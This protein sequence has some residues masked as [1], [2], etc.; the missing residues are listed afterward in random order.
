MDELNTLADKIEDES[1]DMFDDE[2]L[3][4]LFDEVVDLSN[5]PQ[6]DY[7]YVK[8]VFDTLNEDLVDATED[9]VIKAIYDLN[10]PLQYSSW[11][12][13]IKGELGE[14]TDN[15]PMSAEDYSDA[16]AQLKAL[17]EAFANT[18]TNEDRN[19]L[20][21]IVVQGRK[22]LEKNNY[23]IDRLTDLKHHIE[24]N[25]EMCK[26]TY[27]ELVSVGLGL[28]S[29]LP[30]RN[31]FTDS[32]S[33]VNYRQAIEAVDGRLAA[34]GVIGGIVG[35]GIIYKIFKWIREKFFGSAKDVAEKAGEAAEATTALLEEN[36]SHNGD[37][38]PKESSEAFYD[39]ITKIYPFTE[40]EKRRI[41]SGD[42]TPAQLREEMVKKALNGDMTAILDG[43]STEEVIQ[44]I[45]KS[46]NML[47]KE[48][49]PTMKSII[50]SIKTE[51]AS[52]IDASKP[53][54]DSFFG[55]LTSFMTG[56]PKPP[57]NAGNAVESLVKN[58]KMIA[59]AVGRFADPEFEKMCKK[60]SDDTEDIIKKYKGA[61]N[62]NDE[63]MKSINDKVEKLKEYQSK[64][65]NVTRTLAK[66]QQMCAKF[67]LNCGSFEKAVKDAFK[68]KTGKDH[69]AHKKAIEQRV[70]DAFSQH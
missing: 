53:V 3:A 44:I 2:N 52:T 63:K 59:E 6:T 25:R 24:R 41:A 67:I 37:K 56:K 48:I 58:N 34:A 30:D 17:E 70:L 13:V 42:S 46:V 45:D 4:S 69:S 55:K 12:D 16:E 33:P 28:E 9:A 5:Q 61:T 64:L 10:T 47:K 21:A 32:P 31:M 8:D 40:E 15:R 14:I 36:K 27:D 68:E 54:N 20:L 19:E 57:A 35:L 60:I 18:P 43:S 7:E 23:R 62:V 11:S 22:I 49:V 38:I 50:E 39:K 66:I 1:E 26:S 29:R 65:T 51:Q